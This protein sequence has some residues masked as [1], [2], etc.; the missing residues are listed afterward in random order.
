MNDMTK[1]AAEVLRMD[2]AAT[3]G[4]WFRVN[5][6]WRDDDTFPWIVAG[7]EDPH[8]GTPVLDSLADECD[9]EYAEANTALAAHYRAAAPALAREVQRL[10]AERDEGWQA[11]SNTAHKL[12][13]AESILAE[14]VREFDDTTDAS[15]DR[16]TWEWSGGGST[17]VSLIERA[18]QLLKGTSE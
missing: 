17:P 12:E 8:A 10:T 18:R 16:E 1:L 15:L 4:P 3:P 7:N 14:I 5:C 9:S 11:A 2:A 13:A 6:P